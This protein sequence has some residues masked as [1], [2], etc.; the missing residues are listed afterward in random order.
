MQP[1]DV[2][3]PTCRTRPEVEDQI[4][5]IIRTAGV[6]V[7]VIATCQPICSAKNRN[8]GL[9][10]AQSEIVVM[11]DDDVTG[12]PKDWVSG[13]VQ[14]MRDFPNCVM[15]SAQ[16][17]RPEGGYGLMMGCPHGR[18]IGSG[19][20]PIDG[21]HLLTACIAIRN[22]GL[23]FNEAFLGSG[24]EDNAYNDLQRET[25]PNAVWLVQHDIQVTHRNEM[26]FQRENFRRNQEYYTQTRRNKL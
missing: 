1:I 17:M 7:N 10:Q 4:A 22:D 19:L 5:E 2:I 20:H 11:I 12:L 21:P 3:I 16:L 26:K 14:V 13:L 24:W 8:I 25:Y 18:P 23:R 6:P 9:D 15:V